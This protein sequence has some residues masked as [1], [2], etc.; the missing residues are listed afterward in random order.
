MLSFSFQKQESI[1][2]ILTKLSFVA[3][4][5]LLSPI[6]TYGFLLLKR[7]TKHNKSIRNKNED[8]T[9]KN[10]HPIANTPDRIN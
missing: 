9:S 5:A 7:K 4:N 1:N 8:K 2:V 6:L 10:L 3:G